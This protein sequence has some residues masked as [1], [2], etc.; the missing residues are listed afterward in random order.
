MS[1]MLEK[2][3]ELLG[4]A[5]AVTIDDG[6]YLANWDVSPQ[7][8]QAD[9]EVAYFS[10][11]DDEGNYSCILTEGGIGGGHF[12]EDGSFHCEDREGEPVVVRMFKVEPLKP[13]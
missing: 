13:L 3:L 2:F 8:G 12:A 6:A 7:E 9:N 1:E 4:R 5:D 10:W 11:V